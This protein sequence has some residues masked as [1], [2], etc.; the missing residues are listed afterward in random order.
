MTVC[1]HGKVKYNAHVKGVIFGKTQ[2]F[3][4]PPNDC[5]EVICGEWSSSD[6]REGGN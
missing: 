2:A 5:T 3:L 6:V 4:F 1:K